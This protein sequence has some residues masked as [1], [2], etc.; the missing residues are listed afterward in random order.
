MLRSVLVALDGSVY[1]ETATSLALD[2]AARSGARLLGVGVLDRDS[3]E[4][5]EPVP[6]GG[7]AYK[8]DRDDARM[9]AAHRQ[10]AEFLEVFRARGAV[11][12]VK[13]DVL[14]EMVIRRSASCAR[15]TAATR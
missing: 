5:A 9:A 3:I 6:L 8:K 7:A 13:T 1:S 2:W 15:P 12:G 14:G 11:A 10:V 4:R